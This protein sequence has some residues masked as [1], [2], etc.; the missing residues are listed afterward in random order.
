MES[1]EKIWNP[2]IRVNDSTARV[3]GD[4]VL[5]LFPSMLIT[6]F[7]YGIRP[8]LLIAVCVSSAVL[9]EWLFSMIFL[10]KKNSVNDLS[11]VVTG[12]LLSFVLPPYIPLYVAAFGGAV[13]VIFG[14][15]AV[16]GLGRNTFN[17]ALLGR[18]FIVVFF[19]PVMINK[20]IWGGGGLLKYDGIKIFDFADTIGLADYLNRVFFNPNGVIGEYSIVLLVIGGI[21]LIYRE[22]ISWHIPLSMLSV[23][24]LGLLVFTYLNFGIKMS[25]GGMVLASAYI[26]TDMA[27]SPAAPAAKIYYGAM[28][29]VAIILF[30]VN[31]I[32]Y[33]TLSYAILTI[34]IFKNP[35]DRLC[36]P[37]VFGTK[38]EVF[39]RML[40]GFLLF[41]LI[42]AAVLLLVFFHYNR[43][44]K[45][46]AYIYIAWAA[47]TF[48]RSK[49]STKNSLYTEKTK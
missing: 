15:M 49:K 1:T 6:F 32:E 43:L 19:L 9:S 47:V 44:I 13:A 3:M 20:T 26:A 41:I 4:V 30:W 11:A 24:L 14:K 39:K 46:L 2:Y 7:A 21:Y 37:R 45:Y 28:I 16:G 27:T 17:P 23:V 8:W 33:S 10:K 36:R 40:Y 31:R 48:I 38:R 25:L 22:R 34:N 42:V 18:E 35:I 5:A 12:I 29:G